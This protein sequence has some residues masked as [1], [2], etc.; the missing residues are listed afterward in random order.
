MEGCLTF[1]PT[2][3]RKTHL[4]QAIDLSAPQLLAL[5]DEYKQSEKHLAG[6]EPRYESAILIL[7]KF[8]PPDLGEE[9]SQFE[10]MSSFARCSRQRAPAW[11]ERERGSRK[12]QF[13]Q[14]DLVPRYFGEESNV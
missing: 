3:T 12:L 4:N 5:N 9:E 14:W 13:L 2:Y 6:T 10:S 1:F 8:N 11:I 7:S